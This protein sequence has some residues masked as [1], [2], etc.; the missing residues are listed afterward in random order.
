MA[1][2]FKNFNIIIFAQNHNPTIISKEWLTE[3]GMLKEKV[4][5]FAHTPVFSVIE[6]DDYDLMVDPERLM[7]GSKDSSEG[8]IKRVLEITKAYSDNLPEIPYKSLEMRY[9]FEIDS[10]EKHLK[11][12]FAKDDNLFKSVFGE[13]YGIAGILKSE[14]EGFHFNAKFLKFKEKIIG[15]ISYTLSISKNK[16]INKGLQQYPRLLNKSQEIIKV[17]F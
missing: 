3:K 10:D 13:N 1:Y 14:F 5:S 12:L 9:I 7:L 6:T 17:I 15:D 8:K 16:D 2:M 11:E 4:N